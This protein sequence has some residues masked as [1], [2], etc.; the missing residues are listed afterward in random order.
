MLV[1][2][3]L[4]NPGLAFRPGMYAMIK[5]GVEKHTDVLTIPVDALVMEKTN[6]FAYVVADGKAKKT[7][8]KIGFNDGAR[9]EVAGGLEPA[10]AV[11]LVG[12]LVLADAQPVSATEAK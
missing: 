7:A 6:A 5:V 11:I 8:I 3:D 12:K 10:A 4:P 9:V 2:A 1:E